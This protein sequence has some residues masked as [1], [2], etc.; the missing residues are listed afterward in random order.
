MSIRS[1]FLVTLVV[2]D[3]DRALDFYCG[4]MGFELVADTPL[5]ATKRW[6]V[7]RPPGGDGAALLLARADSDVQ[8]DAIGNQTAGRVSFFLKTDDFAGD[9]AR[10]SAKGVRFIE[11]PRHEPYGTVAVF[12]DCYGNLWDLIQHA[13]DAAS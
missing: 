12:E 1:L 10:L 4:I 3:Y 7:V 6:V 2:D 8:T 9:H 13:D 5:E 11:E